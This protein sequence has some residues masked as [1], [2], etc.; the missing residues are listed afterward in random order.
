MVNKTHGTIFL[1]TIMK[2][3][4]ETGTGLRGQGGYFWARGFPTGTYRVGG[5]MFTHLHT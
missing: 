5:R 4:I 2:V 1:N 3:L